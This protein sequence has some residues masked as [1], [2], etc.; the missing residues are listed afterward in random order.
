MNKVRILI[1]NQDPI[2]QNTFIND[3]LIHLKEIIE[4]DIKIIFSDKFK[5][6][7]EWK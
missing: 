6:Y 3:K 7:S 1:V 5:E 2:W 4:G